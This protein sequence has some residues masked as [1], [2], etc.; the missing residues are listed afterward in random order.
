M[1]LGDEALVRRL[2]LNAGVYPVTGELVLIRRGGRV[3]QLTHLVAGRAP[4]VQDETVTMALA[5]AADD[6][7]STE[8]S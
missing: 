3:V 4:A 8:S 2:T 1:P 7:L 6:L 5:T